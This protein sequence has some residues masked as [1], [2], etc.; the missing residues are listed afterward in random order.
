MNGIRHPFTRYLYERD[1]D[2]DGVIRVSDD[3]GAWGRFRWDGSYLEGE[4]REA[5]PQ[6]CNWIAGPKRT[7]HRLQSA[8][9]QPPH[10]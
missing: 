5:D 1:N 2:L 8:D 9:A 7:N 6:L 10:Q 4:L 3:R